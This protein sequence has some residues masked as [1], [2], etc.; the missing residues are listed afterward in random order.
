MRTAIM[1]SGWPRFHA[2]FDEQLE[3]LYGSEIDWIVVFWKTTEDF[4]FPEAHTPSWTE[5]VK[6][7]DDAK[8]WLKQRMP[9]HHNLAHFSFIDCNEFPDDYVISD[10]PNQVTV[11][12]FNTFRQYYMVKKVYEASM[13]Y[14][15]YD[16]IM[17]T[18]PDMSLSIPVH[19][20]KIYERLKQDPMR[21][22][23]PSNDRQGDFNDL[24]AIG[25]PE[26]MQIYS[27]VV[28][29]FNKMY[30]DYN[31]TFHTENLVLHALK[32][33]GVHWMDDGYIA[34]VRKK[35]KFLTPLWTQGVKYYEADFGRW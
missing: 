12:P 20:D 28:D 8:H 14:G 13:A 32:Y 10:Y 5:S 27:T 7:E 18:R 19:L 9:S 2:E 30:F 31:V 11:I 15:P 24:F 6:N 1:L 25:L 34:N 26:T 33:K 4:Y 22:V 23:I 35:G 17:R 3:N 16:L 21:I 29:Y